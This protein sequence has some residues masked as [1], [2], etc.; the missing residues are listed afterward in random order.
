MIIMMSPHF[1]SIIIILVA[2]YSYPVSSSIVMNL[3]LE[4]NILQGRLDAEC[5]MRHLGSASMTRESVGERERPDEGGGET[6]PSF[7]VFSLNFFK[8]S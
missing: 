7:P 1:E 3:S 8:T 4:T 6:S 5:C 2:S